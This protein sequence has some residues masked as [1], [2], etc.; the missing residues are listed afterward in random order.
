MNAKRGFIVPLVIVIIALLAIGGGAYVY[1]HN[2]SANTDTAVNSNTQSSTVTAPDPQKSSSILVTSPKKGEVLNAGQT[3]SV[4]WI[5]E[6]IGNQALFIGLISDKG[7]SVQPFIA[8]GITNTSK[9]SWTVD[10]KLIPSGSYRVVVYTS[11]NLPD[12]KNTASGQSEIFTIKS[13]VAQPTTSAISSITPSVAYVNNATFGM[14]ST[15]TVKGSGFTNDV[16]LA[17]L[18]DASGKTVTDLS[19]N[20]PT[21]TSDNPNQFTISIPNNTKPGSYSIVLENSRFGLKSKPF[22][23]TVSS[24]QA[25]DSNLKT[26]SN[27]NFGMEIKYPNNWVAGI[28]QILPGNAVVFCPSQ[29][30]DSDLQVVCK[31]KQAA[32]LDTQAAI[33]MRLWPIDDAPSNSANRKVFTEASTNS[34]IS[35]ELVDAQYQTIFNQMIASFKFD[36]PDLMTDGI[37]L[38]NIPDSNLIGIWEGNSTPVT[39][40]K[41]TFNSNSSVSYTDSNGTIISGTWSVSK[42][43]Q[44]KITLNNSTDTYRFTWIKFLGDTRLVLA[45]ESSEMVYVRK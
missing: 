33:I 13:N 25:G 7:T 21:G 15:L 17:H 10:T 14:G 16:S 24:S 2:K 38:S 3:Y 6:N 26:Y 43:N 1:T 11:E 39:N 41:Y 36:G 9:Y 42:P 35:I 19:I 30:A 4:E 29:S 34:A 40:T 31:L 8:S 28:S 5:S 45:D 22:P 18:V 32:H 12:G 27:V 37:T 23:I 20:T 44:L